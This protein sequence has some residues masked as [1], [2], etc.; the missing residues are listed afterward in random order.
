M[1]MWKERKR[2][3][4]D[5]SHLGLWIMDLFRGETTTTIRNSLTSNE[6]HISKV[7]ANMTNLHHPLDLMV[8]HT[9]FKAP[10]DVDITLHSSTLEQLQA[11]RII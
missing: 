11:K 1:Y 8:C 10:E 7:P 9:N 4:L 5:I 2:L 3:R 6:I